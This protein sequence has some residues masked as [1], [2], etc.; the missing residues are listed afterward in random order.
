MPASIHKANNPLG[1]IHD[2]S[3]THDIEGLE[4]EK[5][6]AARNTVVEYMHDQ[7]ISLT[8]PEVEAAVQ[9][10]VLNQL[11]SPE[12][13]S[14]LLR[15]KYL[16]K[17]RDGKLFMPHSEQSTSLAKIAIKADISITEL[18]RITCL[19]EVVLPYLVNTLH[20]DILSVWNEVGKS[21]F[22]DMLAVLKILITG[23]KGARSIKAYAIA[24]RLLDETIAIHQSAGQPIPDDETLRQEVVR[25]VIEQAEDFNN[26]ELRA[27]LRSDRTPPIT[28]YHYDRDGEG[29]LIASVSEEQ[30]GILARLAGVS[31][32]VQQTDL[33]GVRTLIHQLGIL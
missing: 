27:Y 30:M 32:E 9:L 18:S 12:L 23:E 29:V 25:D 3:L 28:L 14:M 7:G 4:H 8:D 20:L 10:R 1:F 33:A 31:I 21:N 15:Y 19:V 2:P 17:I 22:F 24:Q 5:V 16:C 11:N 6:E 26:R 13:D